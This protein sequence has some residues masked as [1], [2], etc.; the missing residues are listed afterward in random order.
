MENIFRSVP[1]GVGTKGRIKLSN[2]EMHN[3]FK[4]GALRQFKITMG[5]K[6]ILSLLRKMHYE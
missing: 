1:K 5:M 3:V 2:K 6:E 4:K